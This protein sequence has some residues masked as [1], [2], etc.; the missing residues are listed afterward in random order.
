MGGAVEVCGLVFTQEKGSWLGGQ[1]SL[2]TDNEGPVWLLAEKKKSMFNANAPRQK[3]GVCPR[4]I[5][6]K[7]VI[8]KDSWPAR[9]A[10][11]EEKGGTDQSSVAKKKWQIQCLKG[12]TGGVGGERTSLKKRKVL[13]DKGKKIY[14]EKVSRCRSKG[15]RKELR[16]LT[17]LHRDR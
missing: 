3:G 13:Q 17:R 16:T 7:K 8:N 4:T 9:P 14:L 11:S 6:E 5:W 15:K 10:N 1:K 12:G 2:R